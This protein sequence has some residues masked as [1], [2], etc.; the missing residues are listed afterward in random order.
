MYFASPFPFTAS[1][2]ALSPDGKTLALVAYVQQENRYAIY[3]YEVGKSSS[4]SVGGTEGATHPF[5]SPDG[6]SL[7]FFADGK[8]K[9]V[10]L[11]NGSPQVLADAPRGR[12]G[13]WSSDGTILFAG[14]VFGGLSKVAAGGGTAELFTKPDR[15][16]GH[17]SHRWPMFL[18]DGRHFLYLAANFAGEY[19]KNTILLGSLDSSETRSIVAASS[20][21][22]YA[23]GY[24]F[25]LRDDVLVAQRFDARTYQLS[26]EPR[27]I[28]DQIQYFPETDLGLF[29]TAGDGPVILQTG[30]RGD[31]S[32][33]V[34]LDR[35]GKQ[36]GSLGTP[37]LVADPALSPDGRRVTFEAIDNSGRN[38]DVW[39]Q[40]VGSDVAT[41]LTFG[42]GL[43]EMPAWS[44]DGRRIAHSA[45]RNLQYNVASKN[46]DGSGP[47]DLMGE[48]SGS[49]QGVW[50]WSRD[51][52]YMLLWREDR[53]WY[54]G[55]GDTQARPLASA[56][57]FVRHARFS[58]D[59]R[60][61]AY[62]SNRVGSWEVYV[63]SFPD[64]S[65]T[66]QVSKSGGQEPRWRRDGKE[67]FYLAPD[68]SM[69]AVPVKTGSSFEAGPPA[70]LFQIHP[71]Q[72][73][74]ALDLITY[75]VTADGKK[76][77]VNTKVDEPNAAPLSV[78]LNWSSQL[79]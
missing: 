54:L 42:P 16:R 20:N 34:W 28:A 30:A 64:G 31:K 59:G 13:A 15:A 38:A 47:D 63:S 4:V 40:D 48:P 50:D 74:S 45:V 27:A 73:R 66:W 60:W 78:I 51:G 68:G 33:F 57:R 43:N 41:R 39:I 62:S 2:F 1:N 52:K 17:L 49:P 58:P 67:L 56:G 25:Y 7:G 72:P 12:G 79:H 35:A 76:F 75:D 6:K 14:D 53:L 36:V 32:H 5:W 29:A 18:P 21:M 77:L 11:P 69:M 44:T 55:P 65:S 3:V 22:A 10:D 26:G 19:D 8:L 9:R 46:A 23:Q 71:R 24:L 61:I 70:I 37:G